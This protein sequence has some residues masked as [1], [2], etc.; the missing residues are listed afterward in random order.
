LKIPPLPCAVLLVERIPARTATLM[1]RWLSS[2]HGSLIDPKCWFM[3]FLTENGILECIFSLMSTVTLNFTDLH[4]CAR[5]CSK[6]VHLHGVPLAYV[7]Y[8]SLPIVLYNP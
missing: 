7:C 4:A 8:C 5:L 1:V 6:V 3:A 2:C